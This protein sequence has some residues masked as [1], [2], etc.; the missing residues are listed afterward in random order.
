MSTSRTR[1]NELLNIDS[2]LVKVTA[3]CVSINW[4]DVRSLADRTTVIKG[5][6]WALMENT[7]CKDIFSMVDKIGTVGKC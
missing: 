3:I 4:D 6:Y 5:I 7:K 1:Y 2:I